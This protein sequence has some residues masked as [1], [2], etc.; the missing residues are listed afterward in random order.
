MSRSKDPLLNV[1]VGIEAF[2]R[3]AAD[4]LALWRASV[5]QRQ[6][7]RP[8]ESSGNS[9]RGNARRSDPL[10]TL[11]VALRQER[12]RWAELAEDDSA[13]RRLHDLFAALLDI[14]DDG[15][16]KPGAARRPPRRHAGK[17]QN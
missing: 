15:P 5:E 12:A 9:V 4:G 16:R 13:A 7:C 2:L 17:R 11:R 8:S 6:E 14:L 3:A 10:E 1:V